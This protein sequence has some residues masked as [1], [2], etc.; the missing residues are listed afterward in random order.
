MLMLAD[1]KD[2]TV[3]VGWSVDKERMKRGMAGD[4]SRLGCDVG[5]SGDVDGI[6]KNDAAV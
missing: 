6:W 4:V 2:T 5:V 1:V 3:D